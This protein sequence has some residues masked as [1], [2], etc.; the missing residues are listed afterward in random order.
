MPATPA[1]STNTFFQPLWRRVA[2]TAICV[3]WAALELWGR[4]PT[5]IMVTL[6]L[7]AYCVWTFFIRFPKPPVTTGAPNVPP[8]A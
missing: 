4:D 6:G 7:V 5:W 8:Q 3:V 1:N 2:V